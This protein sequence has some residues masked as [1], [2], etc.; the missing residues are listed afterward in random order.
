[1]LAAEVIER[2]RPGQV[3]G[4]DGGTT[5][6]GIA[7]MIPSSLPITIVTNNPAAAVA[8]ADHPAATVILLG[9][10]VDLTWMTTTGAETVDAWRNYRLDIGVLGVCGLDAETGATT[11]SASEV[12]TKRALIASSTDVVV[13]IPQD[14]VGV[15]APF[16]VAGLEALDIVITDS[17]LPDDITR[18]CAAHGGEVIVADPRS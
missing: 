6:V 17:P 14:K 1:M 15:R 13:A 9:G 3:I 7:A 8:L 11:N 18:A 10:Q 16:V 2:L 12:G 5:C 4:L